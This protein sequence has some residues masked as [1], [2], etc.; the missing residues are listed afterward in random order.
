MQLSFI[1]NKGEWSNCFLIS[2]QPKELSKKHTL[3][4]I[5]SLKSDTFQEKINS[6]EILPI[7][8]KQFYMCDCS[9]KI[10]EFL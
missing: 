4:C 9:N 5:L 2:K 6:V 7:N 8:S 1:D 3:L 10:T